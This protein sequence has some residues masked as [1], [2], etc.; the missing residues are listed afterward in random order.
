MN[1]IEQDLKR[2]LAKVIPANSNTS[3]SNNNKH[4]NIIILWAVIGLIIAFFS[5][6][7]STNSGIYNIGGQVIVNN[8]LQLRNWQDLSRE[9]RITIKAE[10]KKKFPEINDI[11]SGISWGPVTDWL[12]SRGIK[13][14]NTRDLFRG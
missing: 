7:A 11:G 13:A 4:I 3:H 10:A 14:N 6:H 9:E 8:P 12:A 2:H 1:E 5:P